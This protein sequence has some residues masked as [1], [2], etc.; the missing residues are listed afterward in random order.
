MALV[1]TLLVLSGHTARFNQGQKGSKVICM[2]GSFP[3]LITET[4]TQ[5]AE[6]NPVI[7]SADTLNLFGKALYKPFTTA[8]D[9]IP[10]LGF[11]L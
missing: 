6:L 10:S 4:T 9:K 3:S 7:C 8:E 5:S 2:K 1:K 11:I